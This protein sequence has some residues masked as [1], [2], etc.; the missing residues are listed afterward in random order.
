M[1]DKH[2]TLTELQAR[3]SLSDLNVDHWNRITFQLSPDAAL[4]EDLHTHYRFYRID[5][6]TDEKAAVHRLAMGNVIATMSDS[7]ATLLY[8]LL[9]DGQGIHFYIGA[10]G[11]DN[12][13]I[14]DIG[15]RL[16]RAF[17]SNFL[18]AKL[19]AVMPNDIEP[20]TSLAQMK[21]LGVVTGVPTLNEEEAR[22]GDEE[23]QGVERLVNGLAGESWR[24]IIACTPGSPEEIEQILEQIYHLSTQLSSQMK[25]SVQV[26]QN[27][28]DQH[29]RTTGQNVTKTTGTNATETKSRGESRTKNVGVN[30]SQGSSTGTNS[31][32]D[33]KGTN[34]SRGTNSGTTDG[35]STNDSLANGTNESA[36]V[37]SND[38]T[39]DAT[40]TGDGQAVTRE[41]INKGYEELLKHLGESQISRFRQGNSKGMFKTTLFLAARTRAVYERLSASVRSIYQGNNASLTPLRAHLLERD[42]TPQAVTHLGQLLHLAGGGIG[43]EHPYSEAIYSLAT[44]AQ[45]RTQ[46]STWLNS[47]EISLLMGLPDKELAGLKIRKCVDFALNPPTLAAEQQLPLGHV[48]QHGQTLAFKPLMLDKDE[49]N[50]HIFITG[51]TGSGKTT[52]CM[53]LLLE[54]GLPFLVIEPAKTEYRELYQNNPDVEYYCLGREDITPFRLNPFEL[55]SPKETLTGHIDILKNALNAV[56]PMEA[57]MPMIVAEAIIQ[58]YERKGWDIYSNQNMLID[59]PFALNSGAWPNFSDMIRELDSVIESKGMGKEFEEKYRGSLVARLT[60][61]T[62]GTKSRMLNA[63]HSI[64]FDALLD[65]KVVFELDELKDENDKSLLMALIVTRL[66][67]TIKQ[68]YLR[69]PG[70]RHLTLIEEAHRLLSKPEPGE[71]GSKKLGVEMFSNLLAEVRKYGEGLII[72]DQI[73]NK[74]IP[75]VI[76]NTNTKIVHRLFSA[77]DRDVIGDTMSLSDAQKE[78]L[79]SLQTG[80]AVIYGGGWHGAVLTRIKPNADTTGHPIDERVIAHRGGEQWWPQRYRLFPHLAVHVPFN[81]PQ[82]FVAYSQRISNLLRLI[83]LTVPLPA[84]ENKDKLLLRIVE[85]LAGLDACAPDVAQAMVAWTLDNTDLEPDAVR[86]KMPRRV[87]ELLKFIAQAPHD[88]DVAALAARVKDMTKK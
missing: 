14:H 37:G 35:W 24:M 10:A 54:S 79:P 55:V 63:R 40:T 48:I 70:Y 38:G 74:L 52:T 80:Q 6:M 50:K 47:Q 71:G 2:S 12:A 68:R 81:N 73:P 82:E 62:K 27:Q 9:S 36:S 33:N 19:V 57:A 83:A 88:I 31:S 51:V 11:N 59:T 16:E 25:Y 15:T 39:S 17:S 75:D 32:Y 49:L 3:F 20:I 28:S 85:Q 66:A 72:A 30:E 61:L 34:R 1:T 56:F 76:K 67:E 78:F 60:D 26:S 5:E 42:K 53:K 41:E 7:R 21:R 44:A 86:E 77:D 13:A 84:G 64:D 8:M 18:G 65:K 23:F 22:L 29:T 87:A 46:C 45:G 43:A 4:A 69:E 58:A